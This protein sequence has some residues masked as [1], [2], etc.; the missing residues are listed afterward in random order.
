VALQVTG[1]TTLRLRLAVVEPPGLVAV[2]VWR[3][4]ETTVAV[5]PM[6][7][8]EESRLRPVGSGG[9]TE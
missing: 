1:D 2:M 8:V 9:A 4:A 7:P 5:P 3:V 6:T